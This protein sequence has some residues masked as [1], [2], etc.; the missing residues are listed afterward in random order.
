MIHP[1]AIPM[2][3]GFGTVVMTIVLLSIISRFAS[4][5]KEEKETATAAGTTVVDGKRRSTRY[6][7]SY[8]VSTA[9]VVQWLTNTI[10]SILQSNQEHF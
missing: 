6:T 1:L 2:A 8:E 9:I 5:K 4:N 7:C 3:I 10:I